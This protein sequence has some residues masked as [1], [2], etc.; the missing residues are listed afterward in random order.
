[1]IVREGL[2][3]GET[4]VTAGVN[5]LFEGQKVRPAGEEA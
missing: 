2:A 5:L 1:V 4:V 3:P